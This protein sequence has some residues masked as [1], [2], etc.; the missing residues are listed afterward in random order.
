MSRDQD[1]KKPVFLTGLSLLNFQSMPS[2]HLSF[3]G[4]IL[5]IA[6]GLLGLDNVSVS[7]NVSTN[8]Q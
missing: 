6:V 1:K 5:Y 8:V 3:N 2:F 4:G 7:T